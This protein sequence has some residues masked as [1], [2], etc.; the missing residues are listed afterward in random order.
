MLSDDLVNG[1]VICQLAHQPDMFGHLHQTNAVVSVLHGARRGLAATLARKCGPVVVRLV[2]LPGSQIIACSDA[3][4]SVTADGA[5]KPLAGTVGRSSWV[6]GKSCSRM[7]LSMASGFA[8][9][10][11]N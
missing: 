2:C 8:S 3:C 11:A 4:A 1:L 9:W 10:F 5:D 6:L 7:A